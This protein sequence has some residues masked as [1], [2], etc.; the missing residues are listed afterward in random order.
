MLLGLFKS[1]AKKAVVEVEQTL[2]SYLAKT[3]FSVV[4]A[5]QI[6]EFEKALDQVT[7]QMVSA[8]NTMNKEVAE[9]VVAKDRFD[10]ALEDI[11]KINTLLNGPEQLDPG[12]AEKFQ[13]HL[14]KLLGETRQLKEDM[15]RE[16]EEADEATTHHKML[17]D[18]VQ[19]AAKKLTEAKKMLANKKREL[20][21]ATINEARAKEREE[22]QK[23]L[24]G[25]KEK[26]DT[27]GSA[28]GALDLEIKKKNDATTAA[29]AKADA[30][31]ANNPDKVDDD[32]SAFLGKSEPQ[33]KSVEEQIAEL[34]A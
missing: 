33:K 14:D 29:K 8:Q 15:K 19:S 9:A 11:K 12:K 23:I 26:T 7:K 25:I 34:S 27:L 18:A 2:I 22:Q 1:K 17:Q 10:R 20:E 32:I 13:V 24:L 6:E 31:G 21:R 4:E 3:D 28:I 5:Y 16:Q 30:L